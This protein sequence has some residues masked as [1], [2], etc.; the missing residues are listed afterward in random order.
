MGSGVAP[1]SPGCTLMSKPVWAGPTAVTP[2]WPWRASG[3]VLGAVPPTLMGEN[4]SLCPSPAPLSHPGGRD[5]SAGFPRGTK[6]LLDTG[7]GV[8]PVRFQQENPQ[9]SSPSCWEAALSE[10]GVRGFSLTC[11]LQDQGYE[12]PRQCPAPTQGAH[13]GD[14]H[15]QAGGRQ[16]EN[17]ARCSLPWGPR[18]Y[19]AGSLG[20]VPSSWAR[21]DTVLSPPPA[22]CVCSRGGAAAGK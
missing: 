14:W 2:G 17:G 1:C 5:P 7:L 12:G 3:V 10:D 16:G 9:A 19:I 21:R 11:F 4:P 13:P 8:P 6:L 18:A 22:T 20:L 15:G